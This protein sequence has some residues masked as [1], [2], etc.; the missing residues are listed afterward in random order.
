MKIRLR[1][2]TFLAVVDRLKGWNIPFVN[3]VKY[4]G[5]NF[6]KNVT[7]RL[8]LEM[9]EPKAFRKFIRIY[10]LFKSERLSTDI[11]LNLHKALIKSI[12]TC[13]PRLRICSRQ[14]SAKIAA[15]AKQSFPHLWKFSKAHTVSRFAHGFQT[16]V[17][18]WRKY[19]RF[20]LGGCQAYDHSSD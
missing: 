15:P 10:S 19:K 3:S 12:M 13:F 18:I 8:H 1:G 16:S 17:H 9:I 6:D 20:K 14:Q 5:V 7:W 2:F 11:K 4:L